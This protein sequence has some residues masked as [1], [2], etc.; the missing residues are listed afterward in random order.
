MDE[1]STLRRLIRSHWGCAP[2]FLNTHTY[3][4]QCLVPLYSIT[5]IGFFYM[6]QNLRRNGLKAA[7]MVSVDTAL[8]YK[9]A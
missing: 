7:G 4:D 6:K 8:A 3:F 1:S 5:N 9:T 2:V